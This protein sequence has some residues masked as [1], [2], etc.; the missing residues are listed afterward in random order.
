MYQPDPSTG[1]QADPPRPPAPAP[2]RIAVRLMYAGA[3]VSTVPLIVALVFSGD[4]KAYHLRWNGH[5]LSAGGCAAR[6]SMSVEAPQTCGGR[7]G[8]DRDGHG[9]K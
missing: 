4:T 9:A 2:V 8:H 3:A 1:Q 5:S 7:V 6:R